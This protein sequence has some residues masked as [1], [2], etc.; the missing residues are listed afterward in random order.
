MSDEEATM[1]WEVCFFLP[2]SLLVSETIPSPVPSIQFSQSS[3]QGR[4]YPTGSL[5]LNPII[6]PTFNK[7]AAG[8]GKEVPGTG[9][10]NMVANFN[11]TWKSSCL[12]IL[13]YVGFL[14]SAGDEPCFLMFFAV[15]HGTHTGV[16]C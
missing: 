1:R 5:S 8:Q 13:H 2:V 16:V 3:P 4:A 7:S 12:E 14:P 6:T 9:W 11:L 15:V 10:V